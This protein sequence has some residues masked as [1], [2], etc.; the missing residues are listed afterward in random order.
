MNKH[1]VP[2]RVIRLRSPG[3]EQGAK[4]ECESLEAYRSAPAWVLL[5]EPGAGK[6]EA[7]K[8]EADATD[9]V[10]LRIRQFV[11][12]DLDPAWRTKTLFL[13]GLDEVRGGGADTTLDAVRAQ[14]IRLGKP[15][16]RIACR[17]AD[18]NGQLDA[19]TLTGLMEIN[20]LPV[21]ALQPLNDREVSEIL[22]RNHAKPDGEAF[23]R[24]AESRGLGPLLGNPQTLE[25]LAEAVRSAWPSGRGDA[26]ALAVEMLVVEPNPSHRARNRAAREYTPEA[27]CEAAG[28]LFTV[29]LLANLEGFALDEDAAVPG[30]LPLTTT[31]VSDL[32]CARAA[33]RSRLFRSSAVSEECVE[34]LHRSIAEFLA[35]TW[36]KGRMAS[37]QLPAG[38][39]MKLLMGW[40]GRVVSG[41][42]GLYAW[43]ASL[44]DEVGERLIAND[45]LTVLLYGDVGAMAVTRKR[46][47]LN[48]LR[49]EIERNIAFR[50]RLPAVAA[51]GGLS[52]PGLIGDFR[53]ALGTQ[54]RDRVTQSFAYCVLESLD[55][56]APLAELAPD[57][58]GCVRDAS[59]WPVCRQTAL[60][61]WIRAQSDSA[62]VLALLDE[63]NAGRLDDAD[64]EL[65]G[66]LLRHL[67]PTHLPASRLLDYCHT[68]RVENLYGTYRRFFSHDLFTLTSAQ[69]LPDLLDRLASRSDWQNA[70]SG[71][72]DF[73]NWAGRMLVRA[74]TEC[75]DAVSPG[76]LYSW[77]GLDP[78]RAWR[79]DPRGEG[80]QR[81]ADWFAERPDTYKAVLAHGLD[82]L[83]GDPEPW[84]GIYEVERRLRWFPAPADLGAWHLE[85]AGRVSAGEL[86]RHHLREAARCLA[87]GQSD[88]GL[89]L[90]MLEAFCEAHREWQ[91][92]IA[93]LL[94]VEISERDREYRA[95]EQARAV[96]RAER[97]KRRASVLGE[98]LDKIRGGVASASVFY[99]L[100]MLWAGLHHDAGG[101]TPAERYESYCDDDGEVLNA[102]E[103]GFERCL[104][105]T[106]LPSV[107]ATLRL[108][109]KGESPFI[110]FP[111]LLGM[112][113]RWQRDP[114]IADTL[115]EAVLSKLLA[116]QLVAPTVFSDAWF[117]R[118][119]RERPEFV[120]PVYAQYAHSVVRAKRSH[121]SY[122]HELANE[123]D[124]ARLASLVVPELLRSFPRKMPS[125]QLRLLA[126]MLQCALAQRVPDLEEMAAVRL[127]SGGMD[128]GQTVYWHAAA[129]LVA[130]ERWQDP[131]WNY[132][133]RDGRRVAHLS[134]FLEGGLEPLRNVPALS[135]ENLARLVEVLEPYAD[136]NWAS[137]VV[138]AAQRKGDQLRGLVQ[139]LVA[140]GNA[141]ALQ[142]IESLIA[143]PEM[144]RLEYMLASA[145]EEVQVTL[146]EQAYRF[147][148]FKSIKAV[149]NGGPPTGPADLQAL[150]LEAL[151]AI[152]ERLR[153]GNEDRVNN[154]W[155]MVSPP[156]PREENLCR[157]T[158]LPW[159]RSYLT[160]FGVMCE[161]ES[162]YRLN[163]RADIT[164]FV[165]DKLKVPIELKR[166]TNK[167]LWTGLR[168]QLIE[169]YASASE[170]SG[171]GIY[172]VLWFGSGRV[173]RVP[174]SP[175]GSAG[176]VSAD[177]M[178]AKLEA[179]LDAAERRRIAVQV[180]DVSR[181]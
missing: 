56:G 58:L 27:L 153:G 30:Y 141:A 63:I 130:P 138:T 43:L 149:L 60:D 156:R 166:D 83:A 139:G 131:L 117:V 77:L 179:M 123:K 64:D 163:K 32:P 137:G 65:R 54:A 22:E 13:D 180:I 18:W 100:A 82:L 95:R 127:K 140:I 34:P 24:E 80:L 96:E 154:F 165:G 5:G 52:D 172:V 111:C 177:E 69:A 101:E 33:T 152:A 122:E 62:A 155:D 26:F 115:D 10:C 121:L 133:G 104:E 161:P 49:T 118:L 85:L 67:Y 35:G 148:D 72:L 175:D 169:Q 126:S 107:S 47:L 158:V 170:A 23:I 73:S 86:V 90:E 151:D 173:G 178:R 147:P 98:R 110:A 3:E 89:T 51:F 92:F 78:D 150:G 142:A 15:R 176:P 9:S 79:F 20:D 135:P 11:A 75:G 2:R 48:A 174:T 70:E 119:L 160:P 120:A 87:S 91:D 45:P 19:G 108:H 164:L 168:E 157:D 103:E 21:L 36:L 112:A 84:S 50:N 134:T 76:R 167:A 71:G 125:G 6:T 128:V 146:R 41:L 159:L 44:P 106:D 68:P 61:A 109:V 55:N 39:L 171:Y 17:A 8:H 42:R 37:G 99:E 31:G 7:F 116:F 144:N 114:A 74:V 53:Q 93:S 145:R 29:L 81:V 124:Y 57:L 4:P 102:V 25:M 88:Q 1:I 59:W 132:L 46:L 143:R 105:R 14:L 162:D 66:R 40:D 38:R 129:M 94:V 181:V 28:Y 16:F 113:L 136:L 12:A 97:R